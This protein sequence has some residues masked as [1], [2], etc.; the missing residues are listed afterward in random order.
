MNAP[1]AIVRDPWPWSDQTELAK[2]AECF[3]TPAWAV[4][5][6]LDAELLTPMVIDPCCGRGVMAQAADRRGHN[7]YAM[8]KYDWGFGA[9]GLD[10]LHDHDVWGMI[11]GATVFM[12][13]PFS[14][15]EQFVET[16]QECG[17][18]KII[19]FQ[20]FAWYESERRTKFWAKYPPNRVYVC[21]DRA[22][23]WRIDIAPKDRKSGTT[24]AHAWFVWEHGQPPGT[25]LG[26]LSKKRH[27]Q[28]DPVQG[29][30]AE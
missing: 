27:P 18:R 5:A 17:A 16:A 19:C 1:V 7:V 8:D 29:R 21:A 3:E 14:F 26:R 13:P 23:C 15:A 24:T 20:R 9:T 2:E 22:T 30:A 10:F 11:P 4:E 6:I 28:G 12:N 25:L